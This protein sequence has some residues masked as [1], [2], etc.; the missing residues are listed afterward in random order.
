MNLTKVDDVPNERC[1]RRYDGTEAQMYRI[2]KLRPARK[3]LGYIHHFAKLPDAGKSDRG[4][5][6]HLGARHLRT[7]MVGMCLSLDFTRSSLIW[8]RDMP[9]RSALHLQLNI[10]L[11]A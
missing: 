10:G 7:E 8:Y 3:S 6:F 1:E 11:K 5:F 2:E 9:R 4:S